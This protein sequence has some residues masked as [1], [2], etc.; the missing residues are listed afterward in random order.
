MVMTEDSFLNWKNNPRGE[1]RAVFSEGP[2]TVTTFMVPFA[3]AG[4]YHLVVSNRFSV[5]TSKTVKGTADVTCLG[6]A[7]TAS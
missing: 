2:Q 4:S 3:T 1:A 5:F 6:Q 7:A